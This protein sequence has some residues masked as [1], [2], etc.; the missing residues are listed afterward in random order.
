MMES[1][2]IRCDSNLYDQIGDFSLSEKYL[3]VFTRL[4]WKNTRQLRDMLTLMRDR[5]TR[6]V[7][8]TLV[9]FLFKF[10]TGDSNT[11]LASIL[12]NIVKN[13]FNIQEGLFLICDG[14]YASHKKSSNIE[15]QRK[16]YSGQKMVPLRKPVTVCT[17]DGY[18]VDMLG[19]YPVNLNAAEILRMLLQDQ[20]DLR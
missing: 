7:T 16:T 5:H 8:Q 20:N 2:S 19:P 4:T 6:S 10:R 15:F 12:Q 1:L 13:L 14:T 9:V 3:F 18:V 17:T 11:V